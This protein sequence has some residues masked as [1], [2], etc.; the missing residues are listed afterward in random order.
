[1]LESQ[2]D[3]NELGRAE[4]TRQLRALGVEKGGVLLVH[5]SFRATGPVEGG[6]L[7]LI[8]A[9]RDALGPDG[10]LVMPSWSEDMV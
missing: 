2:T 4:V 1:M 6:P 5:A 9:L 8:E 10:T 3:R 7:G